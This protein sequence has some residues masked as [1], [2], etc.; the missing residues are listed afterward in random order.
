MVELIN[1]KYEKGV[2]IKVYS[3][4]YAEGYADENNYGDLG[5]DRK[6]P[7]SLDTEILPKCTPHISDGC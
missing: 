3:P 5:D 6:T 4:A 2:K 7:N 1:I